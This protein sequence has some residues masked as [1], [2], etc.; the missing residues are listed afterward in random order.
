MTIEALVERS[1]AL[2]RQVQPQGPYRLAGYSSGGILAYAIAQFLLDAGQPVAFL[3]LVD[4]VSPGLA[5]AEFADPKE[6]L[7]S[8][9]IDQCRPEELPA[10]ESLRGRA[11]ALALPQIIK[12]LGQSGLLLDDPDVRK[13]VDQE[14]ARWSQRGRFAQTIGDYQ[15]PALPLTLWQFRA[16]E[17]RPSRASQRFGLDKLP[18]ALGWES[19]LPAGSIAL[20]PVP[21]NHSTMMEDPANRGV[22]AASLS[23]AINSGRDL[24]QPLHGKAPSNP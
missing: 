24:V 16:S 8:T 7:L 2:L 13:D 14:A 10:L 11:A 18:P 12:E 15:P 1:V 21:G 4:T 5:P 19:V 23:A 6:M 22:L 3:G 17:V 20:I 9:L